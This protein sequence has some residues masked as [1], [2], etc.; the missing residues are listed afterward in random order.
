MNKKLIGITILVLLLIVSGCTPSPKTE[1]EV[2][3]NTEEEAKKTVIIPSLQLDETYY[4]T[5]LP[6]EESAS[7]GL[8][9][10]NL[11][12]KYDVKEVETGLLRI[13][14]N[15]FSPDKYLFQE[16]QYLKGKTLESWLARSNQTKDGLNPSDEGL[17]GEE[18]AKKAP[19]YI[20]HIVEQNYLVKE[21]NTVKLAGISI[22]LALNSIY[23][24]Q[25]E[26]YGATFEEQL[27]QAQIEEN[28][29]KIAEEV[30]NRMRQIE[31][32][33]DVPIVVGL[34]KQNSR[35]A[36]VPGTYF[37]YSTAPAGK[38]VSDWKPIDEEYVLFPT[39]NSEENYRD[40]DT[41]FRNF[42]QDVET[43]F[44][45]YTG[46]IGTG[47]FKDKQLQKWTITIPIQFYGTS[48]VIGFTQHLAGLVK[49]HFNTSMNVEVQVNSLNGAEALLIKKPGEEE[50]FVHIYTQ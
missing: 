17:T 18:K 33:Q 30:V 27:T 28:G 43:Y 39:A 7:R 4:R 48:E 42:K 22:G 49:E 50:P 41:I 35:N 13:S 24:Y 19:V 3:Q 47:Y 5:I 37:T 38:N 45:N 9:V 26:A 40:L 8:V 6:Y 44:S 15:E 1:T 11:A 16:G 46:V 29:K 31:G 34:F 12:T 36:V 23:Y 10:S 20:T 32:L 2:I 21:E 14:Q 25:K